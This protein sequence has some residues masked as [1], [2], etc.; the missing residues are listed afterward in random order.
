T[1]LPFPRV[2][3]DHERREDA[4]DVLDGEKQREHPIDLRAAREQL[5][6]LDLG[7]ALRGPGI[8]RNHGHAAHL[9]VSVLLT[10]AQPNTGCDPSAARELTMSMTSTRP[11]L[12]PEW[13]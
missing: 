8:R 5:G 11:R 13:P 1:L 9:A 10:M 3:R 7:R 4:G 2:R 6:V 12:I